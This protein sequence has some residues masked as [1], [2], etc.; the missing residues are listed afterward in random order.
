MKKD[1]KKICLLKGGDSK[2]REIS[3]ESSKAYA[4][5]VKDLGYDLAEFDFTGDIP[6]MVNFLKEQNPDCVLNGL[7]GGSGENGTIPAILNLLK[8]PYTHSGV[9]AS[10]IGMNKYIS[11]RFFSN[12]GIRTPKTI[13]RN[14]N[15]FLDNPQM[16]F[17]TKFVIKPIADGSSNGVYIIED[18]SVL[19][20]INWE[21]GENVLIEEYIPGLELTV[22]VMGGK[23]LE[24]T[25]IKVNQGFYDYENKYV[26]G[27]SYHEVPAKIPEK[28]RTEAKKIAEKAHELCGCRGISRTDFRYND[29]TDELYMLELNT[30]PGMTTTSLVP[31]QA[32]YVGISFTQLADW[33]IK[34]ACCD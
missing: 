13:C 4:Q 25:K 11:E 10:A 15:E 32:K 5:A 12:C 27:G 28:V 18:L 34:Q 17:D 21:F 2:E 1:F 3:F 31:E 9:L 8:I 19:S 33:I 26:A 14:W 16:N 23:A 29:V 7:H 30:H 6:A 20:T 22:G 24:V